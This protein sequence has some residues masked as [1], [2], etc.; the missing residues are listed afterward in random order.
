MEVCWK[1]AAYYKMK[2]HTDKCEYRQQ[3]NPQHKTC[4]VTAKQNNCMPSVNVYTAYNG[5][6]TNV[7]ITEFNEDKCDDY[8]IHNL[9]EDGSCKF[10]LPKTNKQKKKSEMQFIREKKF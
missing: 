8:N 7:P 1:T 4:V 6:D 9:F 3:F 10:Y 5:T 2:G